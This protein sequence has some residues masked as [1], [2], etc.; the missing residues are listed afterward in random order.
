MSS[1]C[2]G[3]PSHFDGCLLKG[4]DSSRL[5]PSSGTTI[6]KLFFQP[7]GHQPPMAPHVE[8]LPTEQNG[9]GTEFF[10]NLLCVERIKL[11]AVFPIK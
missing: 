3:L 6:P 7:L 1:W 11:F 9:I 2:A 10:A 5:C 8:R 4:T